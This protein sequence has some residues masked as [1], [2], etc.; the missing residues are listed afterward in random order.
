MQND[1]F[2]QTM[3]VRETLRFAADLKIAASNSEKEEI[4]NE[5]AQNL[6]L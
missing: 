2:L 5:L 1:I 6:K 4:I 3:T